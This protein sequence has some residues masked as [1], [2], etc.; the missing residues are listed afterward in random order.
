ML[1]MMI[2]NILHNIICY[3]ISPYDHSRQNFLNFN[4]SYG[5]V[6]IAVNN[7]RN[8]VLTIFIWKMYGGPLVS[9]ENNHYESKYE[10]KSEFKIDFE[11]KLEVKS[12]FKIKF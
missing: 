10:F 7:N 8:Q 1:I 11:V 4:T 12:E 3:L 9:L 6:G 5:Y 2:I